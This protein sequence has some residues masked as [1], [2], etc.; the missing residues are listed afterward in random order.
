VGAASKVIFSGVSAQMFVALF[1][2]NHEAGER[3]AAGTAIA[4]RASRTARAGLRANEGFMAGESQSRVRFGGG[5]AGRPAGFGL[6]CSRRF[7]S[8][9]VSV[10]LCETLPVISQPQGML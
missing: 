1:A 9:S 4:A 7:T 5:G 6:G 10:S 2:G 3:P 8:K